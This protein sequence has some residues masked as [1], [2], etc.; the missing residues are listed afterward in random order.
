MSFILN[1]SS[2][3]LAIYESFYHNVAF[4]E[5]RRAFNKDGGLSEYTVAGV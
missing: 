2:G 5:P 1:Y 4:G 3:Y